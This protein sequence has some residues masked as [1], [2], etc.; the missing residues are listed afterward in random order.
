MIAE[1]DGG[2]MIVNT[3]EERN[4]KVL[5]PGLKGRKIKLGTA[6]IRRDSP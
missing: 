2:M 5:M 6:I 4:S 3:M 1:I